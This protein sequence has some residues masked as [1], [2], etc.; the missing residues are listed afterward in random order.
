MVYSIFV[1][2]SWTFN[3]YFTTGR[4]G[5]KSA[6]WVESV[7]VQMVNSDIGTRHQKYERDGTF[8][9][10]PIHM[11]DEELTIEVLKKKI[12]EKLNLSGPLDLLQSDRGHSISRSVEKPSAVQ[13][14]YSSLG[15][16]PHNAS[17]LWCHRL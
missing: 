4:K 16:L 9:Y 8:Q 1:C 17:L 2:D 6:G 15:R 14:Y 5:P 10:V 12:A 3:R 7:T 13:T 11:V